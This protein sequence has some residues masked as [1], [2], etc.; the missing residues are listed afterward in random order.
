MAKSKPP[1]ADASAP[2][3][4]RRSTDD[5]DSPG[6]EWTR[7]WI[8]PDRDREKPPRLERLAKAFFGCGSIAF[9]GWFLGLPP[10][11]AVTLFAIG[12]VM[13]LCALLLHVRPGCESR[14]ASPVMS[15]ASRRR[16]R[17]RRPEP[18]QAISRRIDPHKTRRLLFPMTHPQTPRLLYRSSPSPQSSRQP[19]IGVTIIGT[20]HP[21]WRSAKPA[22]P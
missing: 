2:R 18:S 3:H 9:A 19:H 10:T 17:R 22:V 16:C 11:F 13:Y 12:V 15:P 20:H 21:S 1:R 14:A 7:Y 6:R 4:H 5:D 8:R